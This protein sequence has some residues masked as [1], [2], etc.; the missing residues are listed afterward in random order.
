MSDIAV[1][2]QDPRPLYFRIA[3]GLRAEIVSGRLDVGARIP[4][5]AELARSYAV[6][7]VTV[8]EA[9]RLL[10]E[11]GLIK[12]RQGSGTFVTERAMQAR[13]DPENL[14]WPPYAK[15]AHQ[16]RARLLQAD[17]TSPPL[18]SGDGLPVAS[19][20]RML[21]MHV[22]DKG[23]P[24]RL[25]ELFVDR[26]Y[27]DEAPE[28]FDVE[29]VVALLEELHGEDLAQMRHMFTLTVADAFVASQLSIGAGEPLGRLRRVMVNHAGE[30]VYFAVA[31]I[32]ADRIALAWTSR[33]PT[34]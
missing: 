11:E 10:S 1:E 24:M 28:R 17:D 14:N 13:V 19:Y 5:I 2:M 8:R 3:A 31:W 21:R 33:R 4:P 30:V 16:W 12:S 23:T 34:D 26:R 32:R 25:V 6:A 7:P 18:T 22:D 9:L 20:R 27:Y 29:M 15:T